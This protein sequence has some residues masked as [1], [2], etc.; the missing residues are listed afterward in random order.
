M[1]SMRR[2]SLKLGMHSTSR[3]MFLLAALPHQCSSLKR[4]D[5]K[6]YCCEIR[7]LTVIRQIV[8]GKIRILAW[9]NRTQPAFTPDSTGAIHC[10]GNDRLSGSHLHLRTR[11]REHELHI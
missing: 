9:L 11:E 4:R 6:V 10:C 1:T 8:N 2:P 5:T 7:N 3:F